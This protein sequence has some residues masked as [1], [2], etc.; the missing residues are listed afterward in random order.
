MSTRRHRCGQGLVEYALI[1][2][3]VALIC[4][5]GLSLFGHKTA[6]MIEAVTAVIP[7][8]HQADNGPIMTGQLIETTDATAGPISLD[9]NTITQGGPRLGFNTTG[10]QTNGF[11]G[12]VVEPTTGSGQNVNGT[13]S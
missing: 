5:V 12:L 10:N 1:I 9:L 6:G 11:D 4:A 13:G 7:G 8:A 2:A 3:G